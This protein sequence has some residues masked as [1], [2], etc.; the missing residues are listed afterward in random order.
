[1]SSHVLLEQLGTGE[2]TV[3]LDGKAIA[4]T[5]KKDD[6]Q[7]RTRFYDASG[8]E[9]AF[10]RGPI[11][12]EV[13]GPGS[14]LTTTANAAEMPALPPY[15][16]P[17]PSTIPEEPEELPTAATPDPTDTPDATET[18]T[19]TPTASET[20]TVGTATPE[21]STPGTSTP[22]PAE[23]PEPSASPG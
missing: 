8:A 12:I 13:V 17:P 16:P 23:T 5:W 18:R 15:V 1:A 3:F 19:T 22:E 11:W 9:I 2:A 14:G 20:P 21:T 7:G 4:G 6:R 10:N